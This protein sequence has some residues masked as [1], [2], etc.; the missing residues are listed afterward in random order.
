MSDLLYCYPDSDVLKNK[1][2]IVNQEK[3]HEV[4][5]RLT[6]I[7]I[8]D[9]IRK[10]HRGRF[11]LDHAEIHPFP[12]LTTVR[13]REKRNLSAFTGGSSGNPCARRKHG[14]FRLL[15]VLLFCASRVQACGSQCKRRSRHIALP[16]Q[17]RNT[18]QPSF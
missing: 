12:V 13:Q 9:L 4:E 3:L 5:R 7:R 17:L 2:G 1:P 15:S 8:N 10:P 11:D 6:S 16:G 18:M 14:S